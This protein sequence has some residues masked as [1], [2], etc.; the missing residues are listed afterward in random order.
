MIKT[1]KEV[2][3]YN[4][5]LSNAINGVSEIKKKKLSQLFEGIKIKKDKVKKKKNKK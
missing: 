5:K 2:Q 4:R 1:I 3:E